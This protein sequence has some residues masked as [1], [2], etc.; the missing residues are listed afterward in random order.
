M[1]R[2]EFFELTGCLGLAATSFPRLAKAQT[3]PSYDGPLFLSI[4]C[5]GGWDPTSFSD[6]KG[7][8]A[9][10]EPSPMNYSLMDTIKRPTMGAGA[11]DSAIR[12][13]PMGMN[14][15][16]FERFW[17]KLLVINGIDT[18]TNNHMSGTRH[19]NSGV[20]DEGH[21][22]LTSMV[23]AVHGGNMPLGFITN[24]GYDV[25]RG[26][27]SRTRV[28]NLNSLRQISFPTRI[29]D[30]TNYIHDDTFNTIKRY[31]QERLQR[32]M[33]SVRLPRLRRTLDKFMGVHS[34][35]NELSR[36]ETYLPELN[37]FQ[38]GLGRQGAVA[39]A[40][41]RAGVTISANLTT[42][43]FDTHG[44][45]DQNQSNALNRLSTGIAEIW[46]QVEAAGL[47]DKVTILVSSDF[48][49]TPGYNMG[50][51]KDHW[52]ITSMLLMGAGITGNRVLGATTHGHRTIP[53]NRETF[54]PDEDGI[55]LTPA[56][57]HRAL[58]EML[59][60]NAHNV[61]RDFP[62]TAELLPILQG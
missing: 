58:R 34:S 3:S 18:S 2:R 52:P 7:R 4:H 51:G 33:D 36:L 10:D 50:N 30:A 45:H 62:L 53:V 56:H 40:G 49:R 32:K 46:D 12:W 26:V 16:F 41:Y 14:D 38:T 6:P 24:G 9:E 57:V 15:A 22:C 59:G 48:G 21:P 8:Q 35:E 17:S 28:G 42:G 20:L 39:L 43:G 27:V 47:E 5:G 61:A 37:M 55:I 60:V 23:A 31:Q 29:D 1:N 13:A 44:N 25:T 19:V 54:Q 11:E